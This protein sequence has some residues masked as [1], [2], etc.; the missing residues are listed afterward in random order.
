MLSAAALTV[1]AG[2]CA[3]AAG[4]YKTVEENAENTV[5]EYTLHDAADTAAVSVTDGC[6]NNDAS[7]Y[8]IIGVQYQGVD[9]AGSPIGGIMTDITAYVESGDRLRVSF[10]YRSPDFDVTPVIEVKGADGT[11]SQTYEFDAAQGSG[12]WVPYVSEESEPIVFSEGDKVCLSFMNERGFWHMKGLSIDRFGEARE[13]SVPSDKTWK[14]AVEENAENSV[15]NYTVHDWYDKA[16]V[17]PNTACPNDDATE[18]NISGVQYVGVNYGGS[19]TGGIRTNITK[20]IEPGDR[21]RISF[22]YRSPGFENFV[23]DVT[24]VIEVK[25]PDGTVSWRCELE[26]APQS[27]VWT[28][29]TSGESESIAFS[30]GDSVSL[31][32]MN[33]RGFWHM[34]GLKIERFAGEPREEEPEEQFI[35][36]LK[37]GGAVANG[38]LRNGTVKVSGAVA[39]PCSIY[40]ALYD[41]GILAN[42]SVVEAEGSFELSVK[43]SGADTLKLMA[44]DENMKPMIEEPVTVKSDGSGNYEEEPEEIP[45]EEPTTIKDK[46]EYMFLIGNIYRDAQNEADAELLIK[47]HSI[48]T[49]ENNMKPEWLSPGKNTY[50]YTSA[51]NMIAFA[52]AN[53]LDVIG[54]VLVW[55]SQSPQW[56]TEGTPDEVRTNMEN[57]INTVAGH[58]KGKV[59]GWDVVNEALRDDIAEFPTEWSG[60]YIRKDVDENDISWYYALGNDADYIYDAFVLAHNADPDAE[61]YYNDY[62]LDFPNKREAAALMV[63]YINDRYK[64]ETGSDENLIDAIGM[65]SHYSLNTNVDNVRASID[66]FREIGVRVNITELDVC[67]NT[68]TDNGEGASGEITELSASDEMKQAAKYAEL[69]TV[70]MENADIIDRV[71]FWGYNDGYSWRAPQ[72]PTLFDKDLEPKKAF[73]AVMDPVNYR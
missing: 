33:E 38:V 27:D 13:D 25:R 68:V 41:D 17:E 14:T 58:F 4:W 34:K 19:P 64:A 43:N 40:A 15:F 65:Q 46:Y 29:Y 55:H 69:M 73:Y 52:E 12:V 8:N 45:E 6:P 71:T 49:P 61:L 21:L 2:T 62:N 51:D 31:S 66:R 16:S 63:E 10:D 30:E 53:G 57:Y 22:D 26:V 42:V 72:H 18:Y 5:L 7:E 39:E 35:S 47:H 28:A 23:Y 20:Y 9:Y 1:A 11:V 60:E 56:L 50:N 36:E 3:A 59:K 48:I 32:L 37:I 44:W 54:H 70:Y 24:P 67:I